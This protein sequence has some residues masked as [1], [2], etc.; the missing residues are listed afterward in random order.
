MFSPKQGHYWY[1]FYNVFG[2]NCGPW[3]G[4]EPGTSLTWSQHRLVPILCY[5]E[6]RFW[7]Q[8]LYHYKKISSLKKVTIKEFRVSLLS[9]WYFHFQDPLQPTI[10]SK[11]TTNLNHSKQQKDESAKTLWALCYFQFC[12]FLIEKQ[13]QFRLA[14]MTGLKNWFMGLCTEKCNI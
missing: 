14:M 13:H 3:L 1:H 9:R 8:H 6:V 11:Q 4:I 10:Y 12:D 2:M 7:S 5:F